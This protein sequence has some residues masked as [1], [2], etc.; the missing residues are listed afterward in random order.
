MDKREE[1]KRW[2]AIVVQNA[3]NESSKQIHN[4]IETFLGVSN[5]LAGVL[6][7]RCET[8]RRK[9][10]PHSAPPV[11]PS[12]NAPAPQKPEYKQSDAEGKMASS[13]TMGRAQE[14]SQGRLGGSEGADQVQ[15]SQDQQKREPQAQPRS[16]S[17]YVPNG[18]LKSQ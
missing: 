15:K 10:R 11:R 17:S 16:G 12:S 18:T 5:Q 4:D 7:A 14:R 8:L 13:K 3:A 9:I 1:M 2:I 6:S